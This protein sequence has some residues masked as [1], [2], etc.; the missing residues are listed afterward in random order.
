MKIIRLF[1]TVDCSDE[2][3]P[4]FTGVMYASIVCVPFWLWVAWLIWG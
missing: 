2:A 3:N 4:F 1:K